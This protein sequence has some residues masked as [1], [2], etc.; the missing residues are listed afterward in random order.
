MRHEACRH[1][2]RNMNSLCSKLELLKRKREAE[3]KEGLRNFQ[4]WMLLNEPLVP[5]LEENPKEFRRSCKR[6]FRE[7]LEAAEQWEG[8]PEAVAAPAAAALPA[9]VTDQVCI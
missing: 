2:M 9:A 8:A 6:A 1:K 7:S 4:K 3:F 5:L